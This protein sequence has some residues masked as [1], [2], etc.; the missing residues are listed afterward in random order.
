[1]HEEWRVWGGNEGTV[2]IEGEG[3]GSGGVWGGSGDVGGSG[4]VWG[5]TFVWVIQRFVC[6][7]ST[8]IL[9]VGIAKT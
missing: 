5:V 2:G 3:G 7:H 6:A 8:K 4:C 9:P 1:M